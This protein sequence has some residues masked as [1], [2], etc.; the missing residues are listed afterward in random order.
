MPVPAG[1][2]SKDE[3]AKVHWT[4]PNPGQTVT[5]YADA[6]TDTA[7]RTI[8]HIV[9]H[10]DWFASEESFLDV[11]R[12][13]A[14]RTYD[15]DSSHSD[16]HLTQE[17]VIEALNWAMGPG[18]DVLKKKLQ[19]EGAGF[20]EDNSDV[21]ELVTKPYIFLGFIQYIAYWN[22]NPHDLWYWESERIVDWITALGKR[23]PYAG[24]P[25]RRRCWRSAAPA[26]AGAGE[27]QIVDAQVQ[28]AMTEQRECHAA[29]RRRWRPAHA[30]SISGRPTRN[31][32]R[33]A[34]RGA[35]HAGPIPDQLS[36][37]RR[38]GRWRLTALRRRLSKS[39]RAP[40][41]CRCA[42]H[43]SIVSGRQTCVVP[44]AVSAALWCRSG[45]R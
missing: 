3:P 10:D 2:Q 12:K 16:V 30:W 25:T 42:F 37:R 32:G 27:T 15:P 17:Q 35:A 19:S 23:S 34:V 1:E 22:N 8:A 13:V 18:S 20:A 38:P 5:D 21:F 43:S 41:P 36:L 39:M 31:S 4:L 6:V 40:R 44:A 9:P 11:L 33:R 24:G 7:A 14:D 29:A 28:Q 45:T 26:A